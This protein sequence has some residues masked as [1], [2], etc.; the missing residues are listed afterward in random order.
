M[1]VLLNNDIKYVH[2]QKISV[3]LNAQNSKISIFVQL[4]LTYPVTSCEAER[5]FSCLRRVY[6]YLRNK[7]GTERL[8]NLCLMHIHTDRL[9][10]ISNKEIKSKFLEKKRTLN[11]GGSIGFYF[12]FI[13][14]IYFLLQKIKSTHFFFLFFFSLGGESTKKMEIKNL[15]SSLQFEKITY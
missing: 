13:S 1:L 3:K 12:A 6:N 7:M 10:K 2:P 5:S 4:L 15:S 9:F 14:K 8:T 11:F